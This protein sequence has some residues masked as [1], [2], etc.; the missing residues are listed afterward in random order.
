[1]GKR[2]RARK[3][4]TSE[5]VKVSST[6]VEFAQPLLEFDALADE[7]P[8][9]TTL[10][11]IMKLASTIWNSVTL[12]SSLGGNEN[13]TELLDVLPEPLVPVARVLVAQRSKTVEHL[14]WCITDVEVVEDGRGGVTVRA[15]ARLPVQ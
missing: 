14:P 9:V 10:S 11:E 2:I 13:V 4:S 12:D 5:P 3:R 7:P 1:M 15:K 6:L 8:D